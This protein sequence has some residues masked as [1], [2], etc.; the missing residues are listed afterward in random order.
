MTTVDLQ[1]RA[2]AVDDDQF[3]FN[4][5]LAYNISLDEARRNLRAHAP[6]VHRGLYRNDRLVTQCILYPLRLANGA[7]G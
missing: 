1:Y 6:G 7:A 4:A 3:A 2:V 5:A